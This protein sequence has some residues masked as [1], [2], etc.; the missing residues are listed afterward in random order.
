MKTTVYET[1][2]PIVQQMQYATDGINW[3]CRYLGKYMGRDS[4]GKWMKCKKP[5]EDYINYNLDEVDKNVRLP[6]L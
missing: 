6:K 5:H 2:S 3:Y 1:S 4:Y